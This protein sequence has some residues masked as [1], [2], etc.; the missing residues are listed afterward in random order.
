M[1][2]IFRILKD[3]RPISEATDTIMRGIRLPNM[4]DWVEQQVADTDRYLK[5]LNLPERE[6]R[7]RGQ[8]VLRTVKAT[9]R[10][11]A[12][13]ARLYQRAGDDIWGFRYLTT[14]NNIRPDHQ[15]LH[16]LTLPKDD[17][18][19][20]QWFPPNGWNCKCRIQVMKRKPKRVG[21]AP[22]LEPDPAF[23]FNPGIQLGS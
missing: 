7:R 8:Q 2:S 12:K 15:A 18:F 4:Q 17:P 23:A 19:W 21:K 16:G 13:N 10:Q 14:G 20:Q 9:A 22:D 1:T 3:G 5:S 6:Y 11:A